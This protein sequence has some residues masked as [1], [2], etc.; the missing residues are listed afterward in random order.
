MKNSSTLLNCISTSC[1]LLGQDFEKLKQRTADF[2]G[3]KGFC[4]TTENFMKI[5]LIILKAELKTPIIMMG[6]SGCGKTYVS[7]YVSSVLLEEELR[8]LTLYSGVTESDFVTF[9]KISYRRS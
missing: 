6:E 5:C 4:I 2:K 8:E 9:M 1:K 3:G 7:Q